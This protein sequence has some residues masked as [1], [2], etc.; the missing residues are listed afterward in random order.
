MSPVPPPPAGTI[1]PTDDWTDDASFDFDASPSKPVASSSFLRPMMPASPLRRSLNN[2]HAYEEEEEDLDFDFDEKDG[3]DSFP[4]FPSSATLT[5]KSGSG[6]SMKHVSSTVMGTGPNGIG[7]ITKLSSAPKPAVISNKGSL[8]LKN[9]AVAE[10]WED[11]MDFDDLDL[12]G[13]DDGGEDW[14]AKL[15]KPPTLVKPSSGGLAIRRR[16]M[17]GPDALDD[18][19]FD[20]DEE[21]EED[22]EATLK[23]NATIKA[24]L[25]PPRPR[26]AQTADTTI[27]QKPKVVEEDEE[28]DEDADFE[29]PLTLHNLSL[30][31]RTAHP[32]SGS[33][34]RQPRTSVIS[35]ATDWDS[36]GNSTSTSS[37]KAEFWGGTPPAK[38]FSETSGTSISDG[39]ASAKKSTFGLRKDGDVQEEEEDMEDGLVLPSKTFFSNTSKRELDHLLDRKRKPQY[40]ST[41]GD[42]NGSSAH[43]HGHS[44]SHSYSLARPSVVDEGIEDGLVFEESGKELTMNRLTMGKRIRARSQ[45]PIAVKKTGTNTTSGTGTT[46]LVPK[47]RFDGP[48]ATASSPRHTSHDIRERA[49]STLGLGLGGGGY[50]SHSAGNAHAHV[51]APAPAPASVIQPFSPTRPTSPPATIH[52]SRSGQ[53]LSNLSS[54]G[55]AGAGAGAAPPMT[56]SRLRHQKSYHTLSSPSPTPGGS[57]TLSRKQ[58]LSALQDPGPSTLSHPTLQTLHEDMSSTGGSPVKYHNSTSRLTMPTSSSKAKSKS[59]PPISNIFPMTPSAS[60]AQ[61]QAGAAPLSIRSKIRAGPSMM[62]VA[63]HAY[64]DGSELEGIEDLDVGDFDKDKKSSLP[65]SIRSKCES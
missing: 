26:P 58:S 31:T 42:T 56:P 20:F 44:H 27:K 59:R 18:L 37:K 35:N 1:V 2:A 34:S 62:R 32:A 29:L 50:R 64:S 3:T 14:K 48:A 57:G 36:P 10:A 39:L 33:G 30:A 45:I 9:A 21:E 63:K 15:G 65:R 12:G 5:S 46:R 17:P 54:A 8:K 52:R 19:D 49:H 38:R 51:N 13:D 7:V 11:D 4:A 22:K 60:Q 40:A 6:P 43:G 53:L 61:Q 24:M 41:T 25:P 16:E 28:E 23:A 55:L 47:N